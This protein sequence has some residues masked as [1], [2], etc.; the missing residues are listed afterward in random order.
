M[1]IVVRTAG[2]LFLIVLIG[3]STAY[4]LLP[5]PEEPESFSLND[6]IF[7]RVFQPL[8]KEIVSI[9]VTKTISNEESIRYLQEWERLNSGFDRRDLTELVGFDKPF[10]YLSRM[11][12][13][14]II[15]CRSGMYLR[16]TENYYNQ[17]RSLIHLIERHNAWLKI[18]KP[19]TIDKLAT[20][21][22]GQSA[23]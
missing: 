17:N 2:G 21:F 6:S 3:Y 11:R 13:L 14:V 8:E 19:S 10:S 7:E 23:Y 5:A 18:P 22:C 20:D 15:D 4:F 9:Y 12:R 16:A 1:L